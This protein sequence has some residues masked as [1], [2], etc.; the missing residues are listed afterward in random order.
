MMSLTIAI[1]VPLALAGAR[2][3]QFGSKAAAACGL[4]SVAFG[5]VLIYRICFVD[6]LLTGHIR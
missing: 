1:G 6:G 3:V 4:I 2:D 5:F